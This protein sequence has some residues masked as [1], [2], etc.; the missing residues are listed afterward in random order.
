MK[1]VALV[2][3]GKDSCY[4]MMLCERYGHQVVALANLL[5]SDESVQ[6]LDSYMYQTVGHN[7]IGAY[8]QCMGLPLFRK[9]LK[10]TSKNVSKSYEAPTAGD[11]VEDLRVLLSQVKRSMPDLQAVSCGAIRSD[12]QRVRVETVCESL[13]LVCLSFMW[14]RNQEE[15][16][17]SMVESGV[18]AVLIKVACL[19]LDPRKS[20]GKT[21]G[22][23]FPKLKQL[24]ELYGVHICGEGG[25]YETLTLD[26]PLF[27]YGRIVVDESRCAIDEKEEVGN[28][29]VEKY[30]VEAKTEEAPPEL[31]VVTHVDDALCD[32]IEGMEN[33]RN[34]EDALGESQSTEEECSYSESTSYK[35]VVGSVKKRSSD[36]GNV[37]TG[38][39]VL[40]FDKLMSGI[41]EKLTRVGR[42]FKHAIIVYFYLK[43]MANFASVNKIYKSYF[44]SVN[45]PARCCVEMALSECELLR[46]QV[47]LSGAEELDKGRSILHVQ[48]IS[49]WA[50]CCIGPYSQAAH[51]GECLFIS[52]QLGLDPPLMKFTATNLKQELEL[53]LRHCESVSRALNASVRR[54]LVKLVCFISGAASGGANGKGDDIAGQINEF[55]R[56]D[57]DDSGEGFELSDYDPLVLYVVTEAL[58]KDA[59]IELHPVLH[60]AEDLNEDEDQDQGKVECIAIDGSNGDKK[61][62]SGVFG[63]GIGTKG[64]FCQMAFEVGAGEEIGTEVERVLDQ[65]SL[66]EKD[67][68]TLNIYYSKKTNGISC[69]WGQ[70]QY[71]LCD[72]CGLDDTMQAEALVEVFAT[73]LL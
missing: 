8:A 61:S 12:Y 32:P 31:A 18:H 52:G 72:A 15:L 17:A 50:P 33:R 11:E 47:L 6:E 55:I 67:V 7:L 54:G 20:L 38:D 25:E 41:K 36:A 51:F 68:V 29:V 16:L 65:F 4:N 40:S 39:L 57:D 42:S 14:R 62:S 59:R 26:C 1:T 10:G 22:A 3:G 70:P 27:K 45:P 71:L 44:G 5:P 35:V 49:Q 69:S 34:A 28:Y 48:S 30:H 60:P 24:H 56:S 53:A 58:P 46:I 73:K 37:A 9:K 43:D 13:G 64:R 63:K 66:T 19:G 21:I 23:M 2:S